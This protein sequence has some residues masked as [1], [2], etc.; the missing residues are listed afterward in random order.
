M[1]WPQNRP[2]RNETVAK[3]TSG[4]KKPETTQQRKGIEIVFG[5]NSIF[6]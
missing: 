4:N 3:Q 6:V 1:E 2:K 5:G